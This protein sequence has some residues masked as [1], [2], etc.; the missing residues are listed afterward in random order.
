MVTQSPEKSLEVIAL[1]LGRAHC[2]ALEGLTGIG[3]LVE[4]NIAPGLPSFSLVGLPDAAVNES[5]ER[6]RASFHNIGLQWPNQRV[7]INLSPADRSKSGTSFDLSIA[8]ALLAAMF[9]THLFD[10]VAL[11]G[12]LGLD[13]SVRTIR[14]VLPSV[15]AAQ[16]YGY[17]AVVV[18]AECRDEARLVE[19][20]E[21]YAVAHLRELARLVTGKSIELGA[22]D[23]LCSGS[24][25]S[26]VQSIGASAAV[27]SHG[28]GVSDLG[29]DL[30]DVCGHEEGIAALEI[31]A[32]GRHHVQMIGSPGVGKTML[33][34]RYVGIL[35]PLSTSQ[36]LENAA[37][38]SVCGNF[39]VG[40]N[41]APPFVA[42]HHTTS[43]AAFVGGGA[44]VVYPGAITR[45][46]NGVLYCD[47][48][49]E[50][51]KDAIQALRQPLESGSIE[52][53]RAKSIVRFPA[54]F[55]LVTS[56]NPCRCGM[57][58]DGSAKCT[59]TQQERIRY[60]SHIGGPVRDRLD[61]QLVVRRPSRAQ[62]AL[63][64]SVTTAQARQ[65]VAQACERMQ[66]RNMHIGVVANV[67]GQRFAGAGSGLGTTTVLTNAELPAR[68]LHE[69]T[70][71]SD[72]IQTVFN[73]LLNR[74]EISFRGIDRVLRLSWSLADLEGKGRPGDDEIYRALQLRGN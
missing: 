44:S 2:I 54:R 4:A 45:A 14:G 10:N 32:V 50:F 70:K 43:T 20:I 56:A 64:G 66:A 53:R 1:N 59:C 21:I 6:L 34:R 58:L 19:G 27:N 8:A 11:L 52:I 67:L 74:S 12:E 61:I 73:N 49:P 46:H 42:P 3:V 26:E 40:L 37:I 5:R 29:V 17:R 31:A 38:E 39:S 18:P 30:S 55:Q 22:L 60:R 57:F 71:L 24:T 51:R 72:A 16:Q 15:L 69:H 13:G 33:A 7:T 65:R 62:L 47:E 35:P 36:A 41:L 9:P 63:G 23:E 25:S 28:P 68:W 48:F